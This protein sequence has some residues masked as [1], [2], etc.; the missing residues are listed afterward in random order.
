MQGRGR[1]RWG[2]EEERW[3]ERRRA[4]AG[5]SEKK[6]EREKAKDRVRESTSGGESLRQ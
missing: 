2:G 6:K 4:C 1:E 3:E 5:E